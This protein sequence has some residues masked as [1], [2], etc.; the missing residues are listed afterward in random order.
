[1]PT[2]EQEPLV[3]RYTTQAPGDNWF[4]PGYDVAA[5]NE[6]PAGF[7]TKGTPGAVVRTRWNTSDIWLRREFDLSQTN[8]QQT[9]L[10]IH[11]DEDAEVYLD[12]ILA[13]KVSGYV[14]DYEN[15]PIRPEARATLRPGKHVLAMHCH[16]TTGGQYI[17][18]GL[19]EVE[20]S[21]AK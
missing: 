1:M 2:S 5:W 21:N 8:G 11:H 16:Q 7:G 15:V 13:A 4:Q 3:W 6:G 18:A 20:A 17:D 10:R 14:S 9:N 19:V 12:G